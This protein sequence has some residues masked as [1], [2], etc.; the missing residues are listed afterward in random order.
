MIHNT[1]VIGFGDEAL[2]VDN[3]ETLRNGLELR[4]SVF[5]DN[6]KSFSTDDDGIN[7]EDW[8]YDDDWKNRE[9]DDAGLVDPY[10]RTTPDFTPESGSVLLTGGDSSERR[11]LHSRRLH[12][13]GR[14]ERRQVVG[15]LDFVR[16][17]LR[18]G[19]GADGVECEGE[20]QRFET[21]V[22]HTDCRVGYRSYGRLYSHQIFKDALERNGGFKIFRYY[23]GDPE[24][25]TGSAQVG[26]PGCRPTRGR[27]RWR[28]GHPIGVT[29]LAAVRG[30][31]A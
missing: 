25:V 3:S 13:R 31:S 23:D 16:A 7:E 15:R 21:F 22:V 2:D 11:L 24:L 9:V 18:D 14:P 1:V 27:R 20:M 6:R 30:S 26:P 29:T 28:K 10:D 19:Q 4:N 17:A 12:R 5:A 8:F